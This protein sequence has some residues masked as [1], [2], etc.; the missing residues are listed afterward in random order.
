MTKI[1][2]VTKKTY[3]DLVKQKKLE[4]SKIAKEKELVIQKTKELQFDTFIRTTA[5][6]MLKNSFR[7]DLKV[8][9]G[10]VTSLLDED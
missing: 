3:A 9:R 10:N 5:K 4:A 2:K 7:Y 6:D 8:F 1:S